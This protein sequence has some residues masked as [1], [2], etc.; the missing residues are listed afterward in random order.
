MKRHIE[1]DVDRLLEETGLADDVELAVAVTWRSCFDELA[2][3]SSIPTVSDGPLP[4]DIAI[5]VPGYLVAGTVAL[6]TSVIV[7]SST[8]AGGPIASRRGSR[9]WSDVK[10]VRLHGASS[11]FPI[12]VIDFAG[13]GL[14]SGAPWFISVGPDLGAPAMGAM[15][16]L[17]NE[18]FPLVVAA[19]QDYHSERP[20][21][22]AIRSVLFADVGRQLVEYA[23]GREDVEDDWPDGSLGEVLGTLVSSR[24]TGS[25][26]EL[27]RQRETDALAWNALCEASFGLLREPLR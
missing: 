14:E 4:V 24:F 5:E 22:A 20:E 17:L 26:D 12:N 7:T 2:R 9:L 23:L 16:L 15:L 27:R 13:V 10:K 6:T 8:R 3:R 1:I 11:Q 18:R 21:L 19:A 25:F